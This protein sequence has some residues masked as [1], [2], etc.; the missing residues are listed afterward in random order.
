MARPVTW[1]ILDVLIG[2]IM[3]AVA[4]SVASTHIGQ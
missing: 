1:R 4:F 2:V 3:L